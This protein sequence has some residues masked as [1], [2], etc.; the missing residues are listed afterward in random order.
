MNKRSRNI[1]IA[2]GGT[3][4]HMLPAEALSHELTRRGYNIVLITDERGLRY[5]DTFITS[6][7]FVIRA[8]SPDRSGRISAVL[9]VLAGTREARRILKAVRPMAVVSFGGYPA[10]PSVL[11]AK[12]T[13]TPYFLH[14]QNAVLGKSHRLVAAGARAL[15]VSFEDTQRLP[16]GIRERT[17]VTGTPVRAG[18]AA[19]ADTEYPKPDVDGLSRVLVLGGSQG[20][21]ILSDIVPAG[22]SLMPGSMQRRLQIS[23]QCR[24]EDLDRVRASYEASGITADVATYFEDLPERL[25]WTHLV[26]SRAG[27]STVSELAVAGRP[28]LLVPLRIATDD[29]QTANARS[30]TESGGAWGLSEDEFTPAALAKFMQRLMRFPDALADAAK[31]VQQ[32]GRP[33]A[34]KLLADLV[35]DGLWSVK[36]IGQ[37]R[38]AER[39]RSARHSTETENKDRRVMA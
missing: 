37:S 31:A 14:E 19:L 8:G 12:L 15:A 1:I 2:A 35:E 26:I 5:A 39:D 7:R 29:H 25:R 20:A 9:N 28:A 34:T 13:R 11:A 27:A 38:G 30:L 6:Q 23:Q 10:L 16:R 33:E 32:V 22:L 17:V 24:E 36:L 18:I 21:R 4:G 3:G